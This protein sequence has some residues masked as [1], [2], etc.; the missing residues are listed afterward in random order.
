MPGGRGRVVYRFP[1]D[2]NLGLFVESLWSKM[3]EER[4]SVDYARC[5]VTLVDPPDTAV[6]HATGLSAHEVLP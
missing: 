6:D 2:T 1:S 4:F 3:P 5:E